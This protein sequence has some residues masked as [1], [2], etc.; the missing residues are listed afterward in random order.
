[1]KKRQ[2][3]GMTLALC[4][5]VALVVPVQAANIERANAESA[6]FSRLAAAGF[7]SPGT[8]QDTLVRGAFAQ[9]IN[10]V[11]AQEETSDSIANYTD[12][13]S[14]SPYYLELAR[15]LS[16]GYLSGTGPDTLSPAALV[17]RE[18]AA[19]IL[20][21]LCGAPAADTAILGLYADGDSVSAWARAGVAAMLK[22]GI[23]TAKGGLLQPKAGIT[24][25]EAA[26]MLDKLTGTLQ[27]FG[28]VVVA[29][30]VYTYGTDVEGTQLG[31]SDI[32]YA[33]VGEAL[34]GTLY[35][36][37]D[38]SFGEFWYGELN[39]ISDETSAQSAEYLN[40]SNSEQ[41]EDIY[42]GV[43]KSTWDNDSGMYDAITRAT[44]GYG[45]YRAAFIHNVELTRDDGT[46]ELYGHEI[47]RDPDAPAGFSVDLNTTNTLGIGMT[48]NTRLD[49]ANTT[50]YT[51]DTNTTYD[52]CIAAGG[53][54]Y[55]ILGIRKVPVAVTATA[56][57][58]AVI[59]NVAGVDAG[60]NADFLAAVAGISD[61]DTAALYGAKTLYAGGVFG[62]RN[63]A[64]GQ[65][66]TVLTG[67]VFL[68]DG[69]DGTKG[70]A[71][72]DGYADLTLYI[73]Y[74]DFAQYTRGSIATLDEATLDTLYKS[75]ESTF[76]ANREAGVDVAEFMDYALNFYGAKLQWAGPDGEFDTDDD[77]TVGNMLH[78]DAYYSF[79]H[80]H[81]I[82]ASITKGFERFAGLGDGHYRI[83]MMSDGYADVTVEARDLVLD[84]SAPVLVDE[85]VEALGDSD[86]FT[87]EV[88]AS[89][90]AV[91]KD[92]DQTAV[93]MAS[94]ALAE[95]YDF[96][97]SREIVVAPSAVEALEGGKFAVTFQ[98]NEAALA[99]LEGNTMY[100][101]NIAALEDI[102]ATALTIHYA[103]AE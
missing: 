88:D 29:G 43:Q 64:I 27:P 21:R 20:S 97:I 13:S 76:A 33:P 92:A 100:T 19:V 49:A 9:L 10:R 46:K 1:M 31:D 59:A 5:A 94:L 36:V 37:K 51:P 81:Y 71:H 25:G 28:R 6:A 69:T 14:D 96:T 58:E 15:A 82:E 8:A 78:K 93:Y 41:T 77:M 4:M 102:Q 50:N 22:A 48:A 53:G 86:S 7:V 75:S 39:T 47:Y 90:I 44:V 26:L 16:V 32:A 2:L 95:T 103:P 68:G 17:T 65:A 3:L 18:Q 67:D 54:G 89:A 74:E 57:V 99:A 87:V 73:Y 40:Y 98:L 60:I 66:D 63:T 45:I 38:M 79:N 52:T 72:G 12:V 11:I 24:C 85:D 35:G 84:F 55:T 42:A 30:T 101:L 34:T 80:G 70:V 56:L 83:T 62:P 61:I 91:S 23:F